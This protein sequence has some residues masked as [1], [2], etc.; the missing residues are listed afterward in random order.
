MLSL[1]LSCNGVAEIVLIDANNFDFQSNIIAESVVVPSSEDSPVD[2]SGLNKDILSQ[3]V[4][5]TIDIDELNIV[6]FADLTKDEVI[7][8]INN[9]TLK[10]SDLTGFVAYEPEGGAAS[11][12]LSEFSISGTFVDVTSEIQEGMGTYLISASSP[13]EYLSFVFFEPTIGAAPA[14]IALTGESAVLEFELDLDAG[15][16]LMTPDAAQVVVTWSELTTNGAGNP[17]V[18]SNID[19][20]MLARYTLSFEELEERFLEL[21]DIADEL[22]T[23]DVAG[24]GSYDLMTL[25]G[26][27]GFTGEGTWLLAM[28]CSTCVNP[29]PQFVGLFE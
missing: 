18:L 15:E 28:R 12:M 27:T 17:L 22:Y 4:D 20:L 2:W 1:L 25:E 23:A 11:A 16:R 8:G 5:P 24:L 14:T 13:D 26:F 7:D 29:S 6:R 21:E 19:R 3:D 9:E 10:Q